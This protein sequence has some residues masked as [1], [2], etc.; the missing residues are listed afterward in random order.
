MTVT[1]QPRP[2]WALHLLAGLWSCGGGVI[3]SADA[4]PPP[5]PGLAVLQ[6]DCDPRDV[7]VSIDD[8]YAGLLTGYRGALIAIK[9]GPH[10]LRLSH[11]GCLPA[12][13][14]VTIAQEGSA[15]TT[16]LVCAEAP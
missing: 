5:P 3:Q 10:R 14:E 15:L 11:A 4:P 7:E 16:H 8:A 1:L 13:F 9:P 12:Y 6:I 2:R